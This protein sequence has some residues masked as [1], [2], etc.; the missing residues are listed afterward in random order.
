MQRPRAA[1]SNAVV[2]GSGPNGLSAA[3]TLARAGWRVLVVE[4]AAQF[5]GGL[6]SAALTLPGFTHDVCA[7]VLGLGAVSPAFRDLPLAQHGL[8]WAVPEIAAAHPLDTGD[9]AFVSQS[10][11]ETTRGLGADGWAWR[12]LVEPLVQRWDQL[13]EDVLSPLPLPPRHLF[14]LA[15]FGVRAIWSARGL[16]RAWFRTEP[17]R[18]LFAGFAAHSFLS[19]DAPL[20]AAFGVMLAVNAHCTGWVLARGGSQRF[21][22]ALVA[23]AQSL[24]VEFVAEWEVKTLADLPPARAVL[25]DITPRQLIAL[26]GDRMPAAYRSRL[27]RF[28]YGPGAS[29]LTTH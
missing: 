5:G 24:G 4:R 28:R 19:L 22:D 21:A 7:T 1:R 29:R 3:M 10:F 20:S 8:A 13:A 15:A 17:A 16:A 12:A 25:C 9:A 27:A 2:V 11:D 14:A 18:A 23:H 6:R 26:A